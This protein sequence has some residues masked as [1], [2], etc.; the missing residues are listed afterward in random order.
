MAIINTQR[1]SKT[2]NAKSGAWRLKN[3]I[4]H[5]KLNTSC[6]AYILRAMFLSLEFDSYII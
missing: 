3:T 1:T 6:V 4:D 5:K 2:I